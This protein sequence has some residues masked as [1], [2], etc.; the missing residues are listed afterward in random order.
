MVCVVRTSVRVGA[1]RVDRKT[2]LSEAAQAADGGYLVR[3]QVEM[4]N[5]GHTAQSRDGRYRVGVKVE[6]PVTTGICWPGSGKKE[7]PIINN[8]TG[9]G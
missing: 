1:Y 3:R 2:N 4:R 8:K 9:P 7:N 5:V 6:C